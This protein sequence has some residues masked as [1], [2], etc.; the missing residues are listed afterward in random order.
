MKSKRKTNRIQVKLE[1][2]T[3][4]G[5][6][7]LCLLT[8]LS[9][10]QKGTDTE[11][12]TPSEVVAKVR[13]AAQLLETNG[14]SGLSQLRDAT[15]EYS[16]KDTYVFSFNCDEDRVLANPAFPDKVGGDI[17]QHTDYNGFQYGQEMCAG[18]NNP[19][20]IW[21]EYV[22]PRPGSE[23]PLRK[24]SYVMTVKGLGIQVGA[25]I[26]DDS[27]TMAELNALIE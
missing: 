2:G 26:Y 18:K 20:G 17:K 7:V 15:S 12:A 13:K 6:L 11:H 5:L 14:L 1:K 8:L 16:W 19:N 9:C 22:W 27:V 21:V 3:N 23:E 25:G 10:K 24:I 4:P